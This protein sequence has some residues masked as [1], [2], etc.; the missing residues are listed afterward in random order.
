MASK[1]FIYLPAV[2]KCIPLG[3]YVAGLRLAKANPDAEF[4]H[5]LTTWWQGTGA[6]IMRQFRDSIHDRINQGIPAIERGRS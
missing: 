4:K 6:E 2:D 5:T 3:A 1:R